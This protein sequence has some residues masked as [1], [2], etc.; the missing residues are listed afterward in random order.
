MPAF[1]CKKCGAP[2]EI[3]EG[4]TVCECEFCGVTQT[5]PRTTSDQVINMFNR[6]NH[7]RQ[8]CEFDKAAD[9]YERLLAQEEGDSEIHWS[10]VL[11][12]Y[13]IEYVDDP[14]TRKK[15][16]TCHR[17]QY[18]NILEDPDYLTALDLADT[19]QRSVYEEEARAISEIQKGILEISSKEKP[20]D[21]FICYKE[22]G[23]D[24]KRTQDSVLAQELYY[25][26]TQEGFK[27]FF[28]RIT[29]ESKLG[30]QYEPYIFAALNS[31]KVMVVVGTKPEYF[32][33]VWVRNE[34]SRYLMLMQNDRTRTLIPAYR[35]MDPYDIPEALSMFQA[36]DMSKLGFMQDLIR[37]IKK[38]VSKDEQP[39]QQVVRETVVQSAGSANVENLL[40]RGNLCLEDSKWDEARKYFDDVLNE[41]VEEYRAYIGLLCAEQNV[42]NE[43]AL[44][45]LEEDFIDSDYYK[46]AC[47]FGGAEIKNRLFG[48]YQH[49][50]Y[51]R[52]ERTF[53]TAQSP[54]K[55]DEAKEIFRALGSFA[56]SVQKIEECT[57]KKNGFL[58]DDAVSKMNSASTDTDYLAVKG[59]FEAIRSYKDSAEK[60][61]ECEQLAKEYIYQNAVEAMNNSSTYSEYYSA[62]HHFNDL[63]DYKFSSEKIS[64]CKLLANECLYKEGLEAMLNYQYIVARSKFHNLGDY[65]DSSDKL[66]ECEKMIVIAQK[67]DTTKQNMTGIISVHTLKEYADIFDTIS[68]YR[69]SAKLAEICREKV[70]KLEAD[71]EAKANAE[72]KQAKKEKT[73]AIGT[74][75]IILV[76]MILIG[77][78][79]FVRN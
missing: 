47:R 28:S 79:V 27:V 22:T 25:Q 4:M 50:L 74:I 58:Y 8:Q 73:I 3:T 65:K 21:V 1:N 16:P 70:I 12:R 75:I 44:V 68:D 67:Y 66:E 78:I 24:G 15:I 52:A 34:W 29:L 36:Q 11:C 18:K 9:I 42:V 46:K 43:Q 41:N 39:V 14:V 54:E 53:R 49:G 33:A 61:A 55:C 62:I 37:G 38:I 71:A 19:V 57:E 45:T 6:A 2:L 63:G 48:Y 13:G 23:D 56:D 59:L 72:M 30:V 32:N 69:D 64:E 26:L 40:K 7:F 5:L 76:M 51:N 20:F 77:V 60:A 10:L 17:V 31:A 35:D